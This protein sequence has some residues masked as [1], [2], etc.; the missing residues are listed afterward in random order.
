MNDLLKPLGLF[1]WVAVLSSAGSVR[2]HSELAMNHYR[3][4]S[5]IRDAQSALWQDES[6]SPE[7]LENSLIALRSALD[8]LAQPEVQ[9][10]AL[11]N[12][13]L[14]YRG[15]NVR[16][17]MLMIEARLGRADRV[18]EQLRYLRHYGVHAGA[19]SELLEQLP[20]AILGDAAVAE[21]L[22]AW[23]AFD[24]IAGAE[25]LSGPFTENLTVAEKVAGLSRLWSMAREYFVHFD[26]VPELDWDSAY[27]EAIDKVLA[28]QSTEDYYRE[29][30]RLVA[31]LGDSH[32]NVYPPDALA[33]RF[34]ARPPIRSRLLDESVVVTDV[35]SQEIR[36]Q[37]I[38]PGTEIL[39]IDG[40]P[41]REFAGKRIAPY[42]SASTDQDL[43]VR[44]YTYGL[45]SGPADQ[46][47]LMEIRQA[48]GTIESI[49]VARGGYGDASLP[50]PFQ[51]R[52]LEG[53]IRY[54]SLDSFADQSALEAFQDAWADILQAEGLIL[55]L[56]NNG[57]GGSW[58]GYRILAHLIDEPVFP[59]AVWSRRNDSMR[60]AGGASVQF[61]PHP[62]RPIQPIDGKRFD[63]PVVFL[64]GART[65]SA[66]EDMVMAFAVA[67]RG[68]LVGETT[69]GST[70]QPL[71]FDLPGGGR[72]RICAKRD[73]WPDGQAMVGIGI[74]P[75]K[76]VV[77]TISDIQAGRDPVIE[78]ARRLIKSMK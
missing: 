2:A 47:I 51:F 76:V 21:E 67:E 15:Y 33:D 42:L 28:T 9:E 68:K 26:G 43:M 70:G 11:G 31:R 25:A 50:E 61:Q 75:D 77:P 3:A 7:T 29:L 22:Q 69:A 27:L 40:M 8:Y 46:A 45:L 38:V 59:A 5:E 73:T 34:Y 23:Q 52:Q 54:L 35:F 66:A 16:Y 53:G 55:D 72:A 63:G 48:D 30:M 64:I 39:S 20:E 12:S 24:R 58:P 71:M 1:L 41:V 10:L 18:A 78:A 60:Q 17:D 6:A 49:V 4:V 37:G 36:D 44:K 56:R 62:V 32:S 13:F 19:Y 14:H 65:F 57:G 74:S